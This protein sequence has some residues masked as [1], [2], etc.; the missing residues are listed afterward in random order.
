MTNDAIGEFVVVN[1]QKFESAMPKARNEYGTRVQRVFFIDEAHRSYALRGEYFKNLILCDPNA[2]FIAL[3]GTPLLSKKERSNLKF[4]DYIHKYFYDKSIADG[5]TLHI[6]KETIATEVRENLHAD[7]QIE[8]SQKPDAADIYESNQFISDLGKYIERD[9]K[10][11]RFVNG[12]SSI[13]GMIVCRSNLQA[14]KIHQWFC[15]NSKLSAGLVISDDGDAKQAAMNKNNQHDFKYEGKP[16]LLVVHFMLTTGYDVARLKKMYLLRGPKAQNLLQTISRV[17]R[18]YKSPNGK[19]YQFGYITDFVD[20]EG[21]YNRTINDYT[22]ELEK[23]LND[24]DGE[25][26][27]LSGLV[28]DVNTILANYRKADSDFTNIIDD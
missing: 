12:D 20:I 26:E 16:D 10:N 3:T 21:E 8:E 24:A 14:K 18:P 23:D 25:S 2:V 19:M 11:F 1:I 27:G 17:N 9:F 7:I 28:V 22:A 5:Y 4:G 15:D 13:G 6:K